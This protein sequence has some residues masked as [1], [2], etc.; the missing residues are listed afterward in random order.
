MR[1]TRLTDKFSSATKQAIATSVIASFAL[2]GTANGEDS[3][4]PVSLITAKDDYVT[5]AVQPCV[6]IAGA[7]W[8]EQNPSGVAVSVA[9]GAESAVTDAQIKQVL[10]HDLRKHGVTNIRF[11]FEQNDARSSVIA[12]HVRGGAEGPYHIG[13][14]REE[15]PAIASYALNSDLILASNT[16]EN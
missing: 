13:N 6:T 9:M 16:L 12:F 2:A 11:F 10:T 8:S 14:V 5:C 1:L 15:I 4:T 3:A 7:E